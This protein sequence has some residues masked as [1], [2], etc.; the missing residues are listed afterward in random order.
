M[1]AC[2]IFYCILFVLYYIS[3]LYSL[4]YGMMYYIGVGQCIVLYHVLY[5]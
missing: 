3:V 4:L 5:L 2:R 1:N